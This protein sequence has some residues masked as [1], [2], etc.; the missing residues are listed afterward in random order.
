MSHCVK[1]GCFSQAKHGIHSSTQYGVNDIKRAAPLPANAGGHVQRI[2]CSALKIQWFCS[3]DTKG[4]ASL[5]AEESK[6]KGRRTEESQGYHAA[7]ETEGRKVEEGSGSCH[8]GWTY[9]EETTRSPSYGELEI[10]SSICS[11]DFF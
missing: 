6:V 4:T 11:Y 9:D 7:D 5:F 10:L 3:H 2:K 1:H 8:S